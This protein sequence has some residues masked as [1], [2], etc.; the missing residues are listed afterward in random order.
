MAPPHDIQKLFELMKLVSRVEVIPGFSSLHGLS[1][2]KISA[3]S[4]EQLSFDHPALKLQ[5]PLTPQLLLPKKD[6]VAL[7][8]YLSIIDD[9]TTYAL[10]LSDPHRARAGVSVSLRVEW[11]PA[12]SKCK[13]GD[14]VNVI[15][16]TTKVGR[17]LGFAQAEVRDSSSD[18]LICFGSHIK[19]L[20]M[21]FF[22]DFVLSSYGWPFAKIYSDYAGGSSTEE[23]DKS[24]S[25]AQSFESFHFHEN[26]NRA[27]FVASPFHASLGGPLHGGCQAVLMELAATEVAEREFGSAA[28]LESISVDY[29]SPPNSKHVEL[30]AAVVKQSQESLMIRVQLICKKKCKSE[31]ILHFTRL[32]PSTG[33]TVQARL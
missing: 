20:P 16:K 30:E 22:A 1:Y 31:G 15:S 2:N 19:Y 12:A 7:S 26:E 18:E 21:G 28:R 4:S 14:L 32:P 29:M 27:T 13:P 11:G 23:E 10:V 9:T 17:N 33:A 24:M 5:L 25:L 3:L 6:S 8:T